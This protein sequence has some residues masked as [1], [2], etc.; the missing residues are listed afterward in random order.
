MRR[1]YIWRNRMDLWT[2]RHRQIYGLKQFSR[3]WN[4]RLDAALKRIGLKGFLYE[5][6]VYYKIEGTRIL[7]AA[8]YVDDLL[9]FPNGTC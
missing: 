9:I 6:C 5:I 3:V 2:K 1:E 8:V 4:M 7:I